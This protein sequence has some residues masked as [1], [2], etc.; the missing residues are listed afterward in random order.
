MKSLDADGKVI[1]LGQAII[2][3]G[4]IDWHRGE[5]KKAYNAHLKV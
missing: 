5:G 4:Y 2:N 3:V 1:E